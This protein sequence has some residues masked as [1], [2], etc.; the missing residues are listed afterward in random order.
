[1]LKSGRLGPTRIVAALVFAGA[2]IAG[3]ANLSIDGR[4]S[5]VGDQ[6]SVAKGDLTTNGDIDVTGYV[7]VRNHITTTDGNLRVN[8]GNLDIIKGQIKAAKFYGSYS[9]SINDGN[10]A[11]ASVD[12]G[13]WDFCVLSTVKITGEDK[14][15]SDSATCQVT[16]P[17]SATYYLARPSWNLKVAAGSKKVRQVY[18]SAI[19]MSYS[20][21]KTGK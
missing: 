16:G 20:D 10:P 11:S 19:C 21:T 3:A 4:V 9:K 15:E 18:C 17:T 6:T 14:Y 12:M 13:A 2:G 5:V 8:V 7:G 1:M